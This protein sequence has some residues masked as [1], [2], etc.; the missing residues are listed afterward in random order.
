MSQV[1]RAHSSPGVC[2][3]G[4]RGRLRRAAWILA[5]VCGLTL[6]MKRYIEKSR[7]KEWALFYLNVKSHSANE[8]LFSLSNYSKYN[9][10]K[11]FEKLKTLLLIHPKQRSQENLSE[12]QLCLKKNRSFHRLP[13]EA[14]LQLCQTAI[15]QEFEAE[16]MV[17][18]QG[19]VPL[20]CYLILA[21]HLKVMSSDTN[22]SKNTNS[23]ILSEF[24]EGDFIGDFYCILAQRVQE[25]YQETCSFLR[26][27]PVF[28]SWPKEKI[29]IL[30]HSSLRRYYRAG[31]TIVSDN[32]KSHFLVFITFGRCRIITQMNYKEISVR[33][34][35]MR[36]G[37]F[38][39]KTSYI[40]FPPREIHDAYRRSLQTSTVSLKTST[41]ASRKK[42]PDTRKPQ[43]Q[44]PS[45]ATC[46]VEIRVLEQGDIFGL[47]ETVDN[48]CDLHLCLISEGAECIFIPK[49]L[50]LAQASTGLR[51]TA[52]ELVGTY[53]TEKAIGEHLIWQQAKL[54]M[55]L[56]RSERIFPLWCSSSKSPLSQ[57]VFLE[58]E[59]LISTQFGETNGKGIIKSI[60]VTIKLVFKE[61]ANSS[62]LDFCNVLP[63]S[64]LLMGFYRAFSPLKPE[65]S[66]KLLQLPEIVVFLFAVNVLL[67]E[68][69]SRK[70]M[71]TVV[72]G[73][74]FPKDHHETNSDAKHMRVFIGS[75]SLG[76]QPAPRQ[77]PKLRALS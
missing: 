57:E 27:L 56:W 25:Q 54:N 73:F 8:L 34:G 16:T 67:L 43:R 47:A 12:I 62:Q 41:S 23:E 69:L 74:E 4:A 59:R 58:T 60:G 68:N 36:T 42:T 20:E 53:P 71:D 24:E 55:V 44:E 9:L 21:G 39:L 35:V 46:F 50:F 19:H 49:T 3:V 66:L 72:P 7:A 1:S 64:L 28:F 48:S 10:S 38:I 65:L 70:K 2:P 32:L 37:S 18:R 76:S 6:Y 14:Q 5:H 26:N 77:P 45:Q 13:N 75:W 15:Y 31:R 52:E 63:P 40:D 30:V 51:K 17:L 22:T 11:N 61:K 33:S 29:D